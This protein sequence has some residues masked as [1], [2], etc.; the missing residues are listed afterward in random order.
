MR[1]APWF[2][3][4]AALGA[5]VA[6][7]LVRSALLPFFVATALA[8]LLAPLVARLARRMGRLWAVV[9]VVLGALGT[10]IGVGMVFLPWLWSQG[11]RFTAS[12]PAWRLALGKKMAPWL[13]DHP[14]VQAKVQA[15]LEGIEPMSLM[16]GLQSA[17][18]GLLGFFLTLMALVLVPLILYYLLLEGPQL[19]VWAD[20]QVPRRHRE[21]VRS[22]VADIHHRLGGYV[23]GQMAV[24]AAMSFIQG[25][26]FMVLGV[27]YAWLLGLVAGVSNL[28]PYSPY[29]TALPVALVLSG[30]EGAGSGRLM[31]IM[32]TFIALQKAEALYFTPVWVGRATRLHP[33]E[34]LLAVLSFGSV[35]GLMGLI[36]AVPLMILV[37]VTGERL[38]AAYHA[39]PWFHGEPEA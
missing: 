15:A 27:P 33:L 26:G 20:E 22:M 31:G 11:A 5:L 30:L 14:M 21:F 10:F 28:V 25:M 6:L 18:E 17:G 38:Q 36:L 3:A 7:Y 24:A 19:L 34:V 9:T 16:R 39:H 35:F 23:R 2:F 13:A 1:R 12:I 8:Y 32:A 29:I 37:K 4:L